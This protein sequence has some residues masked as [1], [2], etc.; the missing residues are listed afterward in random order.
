MS[1]VALEARWLCDCCGKPFS[2]ETDPSS[3]RRLKW[4]L[5]DIAEDALRG[6][7]NGSLHLGEHYCAECTA[8]HDECGHEF[9]EA[10]RCLDCG[11]KR[12]DGSE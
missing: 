9:V 11:M 8:K 2:T 4:S 10:G 5:M 12:D 1:L 7:L 3:T 6:C